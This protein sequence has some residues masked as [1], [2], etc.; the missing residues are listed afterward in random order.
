MLQ[1]E[2]NM[3]SYI[4][5]LSRNKLYTAIEAVGLTVSLAFVIL[6]GTYVWQQ[7]R[8]AYEN[9]DYERVY[10][11]SG[12]TYFGAGYF[13]K[14]VIDEAVPEVEASARYSI[15]GQPKAFKVNGEVALAVPAFIEKDFFDVFPQYDLL[16]GSPD[17][18]D[19]PSNVIV[20]RTFADKISSDGASVIGMQISGAGNPGKTYTIAGVMDDF[21]KTLFGY[22]DLFFNIRET[23]LEQYGF[24]VIGLV[25]TFMKVAEGSDRDALQEKLRP[26]YEKNYHSVTPVLH[27]IDEVYF[28]PDSY[29]TKKVS[30]SL[31]RILLAVVLALLISAV[32]NYINLTFALTGKRAKEMATRR[33]V[34]ASQS[35]IF[36]KNILESVGFTIVCFA[37]AQM[38]A[39]ALVPAMNNLLIGDRQNVVP[40]SLELSFGY[41]MVCII[42]ALVL[43][44]IAGLMPSLNTLRFKPIDVIKGSFRREDKRLF[45]KIFIVVQN[46]LSMILIAMAILMEV[47]LS[48]MASR[49]MNANMNNLYYLYPGQGG[50]YGG[51]AN[52]ED[53]QPLI[54]RIERLPEV[55]A[56][57]IGTG[58][59]G[60]MNTELG[61]PL[62]DG[63]SHVMIQLIVC[64]ST[65]FKLLAP[66][67]VMDFNY[68][69]NGSV[70]L[71]QSAAATVEYSDSSAALIARKFGAST[72]YVGGIYRDIPTGLASESDMNVNSAICVGKPENMASTLALLISTTSESKEVA[73]KIMAEYDAFAKD[74]GIYEPPYIARFLNDSVKR[75]FAPVTRTICLVE[76]F[77]ILSV[78]L[79]LMGLVAMS[80]YFSEQKS[81]E[82]AVR[83]VFGG[84]V[85]TETFTSVRSYMIMVLIAC[86]IGVPIAV[87][88]AGRYL[89]QFAYRIENYWWVFAVAV[90]LSFVIS[91]LSVFWQTISSARTNPA[92]E[93]KKE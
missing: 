28:L 79:S 91:L 63:K 65:Y 52:R 54:D 23:G 11:V 12:E 51:S 3:K 24:N 74:A 58:Y 85:R 44:V 56:V 82:I 32:F 34:G 68:P 87:Y 92:A 10:A 36:I 7:Y 45:T 53:I 13:D 62:N 4:K 71:G 90:V 25:A 67:V 20:S 86:A 31:L 15:E 27:R 8:I 38:I 78:L 35:D 55:N 14:E 48:H 22:S 73:D 33:L 72:T 29:M 2:L 46:A 43:G 80:T 37:L 75:D 1:I 64:D 88:A 69:L 93:L 66:E 81:K 50:T 5:F 40:L 6:I 17:V 89:E 76:L 84:T 19:D 9:P 21:D 60:G 61:M 39:V 59:P 30:A 49:P 41:V 16:E 70:W 47:Q 42:S 18:L 77:M 83:K 26:L 57:G